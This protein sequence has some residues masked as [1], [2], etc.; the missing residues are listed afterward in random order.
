MDPHH[1]YADPDPAV[2]FNADPNT[3]FRFDADPDPAPAS[4]QSD[5]NLRSLVYRPSKGFIL[6]L[7]ASVL[8]VHGPPWLYFEPLK[9]LIFEFYVDQDPAFHSNADP[10]PASKNNADPCI[11]IRNPCSVIWNKCSQRIRR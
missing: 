3:T 11:R 10:D 8:S 6:S 4:C 5:E 7:Q 2:H 9:L 1:L